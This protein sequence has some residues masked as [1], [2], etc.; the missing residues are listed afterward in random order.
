MPSVMNSFIV[1]NQLV[2]MQRW[3]VRTGGPLDGQTIGSIQGR[4]RV[5]VVE[6]RKPG[7]EPELFPAPDTLLEPGDGVILQGPL[8]ALEELWQQNMPAARA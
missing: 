2:A 1:G 3:L 5:G 7:R 8:P 6:F 4:L